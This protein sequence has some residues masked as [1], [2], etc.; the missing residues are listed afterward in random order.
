MTP[1]QRDYLLRL[2]AA[3]KAFQAYHPLDLAQL[4][5]WGAELEQVVGDT[6]WQPIET[7]PKDGTTILLVAEGTVIAA[8]WHDDFGPFQWVFVDDPRESLTGCCDHEGT[9]RVYTNGYPV[10]VPTHWM[11]LPEP[12]QLEQMVKE[13]K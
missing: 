5:M 11:P 7:A 1:S 9:G 6:G 3:L 10:D 13:S 4:Q 12:P 8:W 2:A